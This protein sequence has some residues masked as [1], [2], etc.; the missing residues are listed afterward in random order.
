MGHR[1]PLEAEK[2][3]GSITMDQTKPIDGS[4]ATH[5]E[6]RHVGIDALVK[7]VGPVGMARFLQHFNVSRGLA[8][9]ARACN[10]R[11]V[12]NQSFAR[13]CV[14]TPTPCQQGK[15]DGRQKLMHI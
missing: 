7:A 3:E 2:V 11:V 15:T 14:G 4:A 6:L 1:P 5:A 9:A 13:I 10:M 8:A 12:T